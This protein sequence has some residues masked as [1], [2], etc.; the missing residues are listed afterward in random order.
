MSSVDVTGSQPAFFGVWPKDLSDRFMRFLNIDSGD[1][2]DPL[3][4]SLR[5]GL[6]V[7]HF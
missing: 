3:D 7:G 6:N 5:G 4:E 2:P 1:T